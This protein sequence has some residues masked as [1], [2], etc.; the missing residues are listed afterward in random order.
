ML[1]AGIQET[2][3]EHFTH[4]KHVTITQQRLSVISHG[5]YEVRIYSFLLFI[6]VAIIWV[7]FSSKCSHGEKLEKQIL[8][9]IF[10]GDIHSLERS[11]KKIRKKNFQIKEIGDFSAKLFYYFSILWLVCRLTVNV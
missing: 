1:L 8:S 11:R 2:G 9:V 6:V 10:R 7:F 5:R 3:T 4:I